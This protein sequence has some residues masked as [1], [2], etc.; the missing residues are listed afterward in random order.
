MFPSFTGPA[1]RSM[2][3]KKIDELH[4]DAS[5]TI[6][7]ERISTEMFQSITGGPSPEQS[8]YSIDACDVMHYIG[9]PR[10]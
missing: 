3:V 4:F 8:T 7:L 5:E 9:L 1:A 10:G 2:H 6:E